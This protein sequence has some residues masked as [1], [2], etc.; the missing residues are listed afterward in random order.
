MIGRKSGLRSEH[1]HNDGAVDRRLPLQLHL[2]RGASALRILRRHSLSAVP[3]LLPRDQGQT[4]DC[5]HDKDNHERPKDF[6]RYR[7][8]YRQWIHGPLPQ[9]HNDNGVRLQRTKQKPR[10]GGTLTR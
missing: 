10:F 3:S 9:M 6:R 1:E 8:A 7:N 2:E 5:H 4:Y